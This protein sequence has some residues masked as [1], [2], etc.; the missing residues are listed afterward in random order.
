[1]VLGATRDRKKGGEVNA[2]EKVAMDSKEKIRSCFKGVDPS[3]LE[4]ITTI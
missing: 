3:E 2:G 1:M 4:V